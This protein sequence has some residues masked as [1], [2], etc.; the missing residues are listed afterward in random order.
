MGEWQRV[1]MDSACVIGYRPG[2]RGGQRCDAD[3][4]MIRVNVSDPAQL[5]VADVVIVAGNILFRRVRGHRDLAGDTGQGCQQL[6][7]F[8]GFDRIPSPTSRSATWPQCG[9]GVQESYKRP[10]LCLIQHEFF[11]VHGYGPPWWI[12][13]KRRST[14]ALTRI[15]D[16]SLKNTNI[17]DQRLP[18]TADARSSGWQSARVPHS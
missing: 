13:D 9:Q 11:L 14:A 3:A 2:V 6:T 18:G 16:I 15:S 10:V 1:D 4:A 5:F 8:Q 7:V 17:G 12:L